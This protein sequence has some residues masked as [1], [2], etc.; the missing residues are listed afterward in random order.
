MAEIPA[1]PPQIRGMT[2]AN[3]KHFALEPT[4]IQATIYAG[5]KL[6]TFIFVRGNLTKAYAPIPSS[7]DPAAMGKQRLFRT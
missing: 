5:A 7:N 6:A 4:L 3:S 2:I 1:H